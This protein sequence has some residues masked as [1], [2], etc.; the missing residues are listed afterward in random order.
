MATAGD[1]PALQFPHDF[2]EK[3]RS[4]IDETG[5]KLNEL[6]AS[7]KFLPRRRRVADS[8][9][10]DYWNGGS[11]NNFTHQ[12]GRSFAQWRSTQAAFLIYLRRN[13]RMIKRG[14]CRNDS[15][16]LVLFTNCQDCFQLSGR[17]IRRNFHDYWSWNWCWFIADGMQ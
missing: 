4:A 5:V 3:P 13:R 16:H 10:S 17:D 6:G 14:V 9:R 8:P 11:R 12:C 2:A 7:L 1:A 15:R